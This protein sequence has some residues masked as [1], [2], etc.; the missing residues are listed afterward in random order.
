VVSVGKHCVAGTRISVFGLADSAAVDEEDAAVLVYPRLVRV[1]E[2]E[3][4][5]VGGGGDPLERARGLVLEQVL[6][7]LAR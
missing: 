6:V 7:H 1:S 3:D 5:A 2:D 4:V